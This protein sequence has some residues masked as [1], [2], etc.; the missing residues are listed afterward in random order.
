MGAVALTALPAEAAAAP[1]KSGAP[2][3]EVARKMI[4]DKTQFGC[5]NKLVER[6]SGW[7]VTASNA[8]SGAYGLLQASPG[9]KMASAG[10]DWR[11]NPATQISWGL[12]YMKD[13][14]GGPCGAW[15]FWRA[16][17]WY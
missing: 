8:V 7:R 5:F 11:T 15:S 17:R 3:R 13:R 10:P 6:E 1:R 9:T 16:N 2:A 14:Y 4:P 12:D